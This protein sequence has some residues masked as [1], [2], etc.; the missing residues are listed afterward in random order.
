MIYYRG[1]INNDKVF[2]AVLT[3]RHFRLG[4]S[5]GGTLAKKVAHNVLTVLRCRAVFSFAKAT[6]LVDMSLF[7]E[8]ASQSVVVARFL[9]SRR[10]SRAYGP[11]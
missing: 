4:N 6:G 2:T 3:C 9:W 7:R 11:M 5:S 8:C 1:N 10:R